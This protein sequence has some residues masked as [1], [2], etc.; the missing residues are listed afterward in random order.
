MKLTLLLILISFIPVLAADYSGI[1]AG[2]A[3]SG[4]TDQQRTVSGSV[5]D[6]NNNPLPG[7]TVVIK[8]TT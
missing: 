8:G 3:G 6:N 4:I 1:S 2:I 5:T 7:V